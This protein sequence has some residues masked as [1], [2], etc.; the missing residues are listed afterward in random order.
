MNNDHSDIVS[1]ISVSRLS[2]YLSRCKI[3]ILV[4]NRN[5][6]PSRLAVHPGNAGRLGTYANQSSYTPNSCYSLR[7]DS[8]YFKY[9]R[10]FTLQL[11]GELRKQLNWNFSSLTNAGT[12]ILQKDNQDIYE[13]P[14]YR[15]LES[16]NFANSC[17]SEWSFCLVSNIQDRWVNWLLNY[18]QYRQVHFDYL[19]VINESQIRLFHSRKSK[20]GVN[21]EINKIK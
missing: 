4:R 6:R 7:Y 21:H 9:D 5:I 20:G 1:G 12:I 8:S 15:G 14:C 18:F 3:E 13:I 11:K 17:K 2:K 16:D 10:D 19:L